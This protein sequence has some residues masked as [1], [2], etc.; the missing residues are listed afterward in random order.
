MRETL[1][2]CMRFMV[3]PEILS[4]QPAPPAPVL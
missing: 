1:I 2:Q 4:P 3:N